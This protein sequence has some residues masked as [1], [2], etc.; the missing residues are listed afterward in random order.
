[1]MNVQ[2]LEDKIKEEKAKLALLEDKYASVE[3]ERK[4]SK[5]EY[6]ISRKDEVIERLIE[7]QQV[8]LNREG[9]DEE[10]EDPKDKDAEEEDIVCLECGSDLL[11]LGE[12]IYYCENCGEYYEDEE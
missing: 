2:E 3:D 12:G 9:E 5:L 11:D 4:A 6:S 1:M 8:L 7:R 10:K